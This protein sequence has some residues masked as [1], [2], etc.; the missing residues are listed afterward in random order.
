MSHLRGYLVT[1]SEPSLVPG[2][3]AAVT[4]TEAAPDL[5]ALVTKNTM[6]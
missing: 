2:I 4:P 5:A 6:F 1:A 3:L